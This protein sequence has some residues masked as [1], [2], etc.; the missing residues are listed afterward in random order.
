MSADRCT[1]YAKAVKARRIV[2]G[3]WV[4]LACDRHL[5]DLRQ[6]RKTGLVWRLDLAERAIDFFADLLVLEDGKPFVLEPYQQFIVGSLFGWYN[7]DG[8]RRFRDAYVET[9]KGSGKS[10]L[11]A[12]IG[13]KGLI[14]DGEPA[15]EVYSAATTQ[16]Q[17]K[18]V[19]KDADRMVTQSPELAEAIKQEAACLTYGTPESVFRPVSSEHRGLDGKRVHIGI[20]DELHEHPNA[21]VVDKIRAGTKRRKNALIFRITNSGFD[22]TSV[23]WKE[24]D[25][26]TKVLQGTIDNP[27]WF[28]YVC[29][30]DDKDSWTDEKVWP[31][32]NP[33]M[34]AGLP[35]LSYLREQVMSAVGMPSKENIVKRL[36]LCMWTEQQERWL[37]MDAWDSCPG[38]PIDPASLRGRPCM[39]GLDMASRSD[40]ASTC[41]LFGPDEEGYYEAVWR[42]WLP[43]ESI[44]SAKSKRPESVR[45]QLREWADQGWITLTSGDTT[46]YD[47][48]EEAVLQDVADFDVRKLPFDRWNVTQLVTHLKDAMGDERVIDFPQTMAAMTA[49]TKELEKIVTEG[50]LR[51]GGNPVARWMASNVTIKH[52]PNEQIKPDRDSEDREKIDGI[53]ALIMAIDMVMR[54]PADQSEYD[55]RAEELKRM[56]EEGVAGPTQ[57]LID[58]W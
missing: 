50:K 40:F 1:A 37:P 3:P 57:D 29:A 56:R 22:R 33:A 23:C 44:A 4:R 54:Q 52:G 34:A 10:P 32:A 45:L 6:R 5:R 38:E 12:G 2:A 48:I 58:A 16:D 7:A 36:N 49:P 14:A 25:Y 28:A 51:H 46:D 21:M 43:E 8:F 13:L 47:L 41:K 15:A 27:S 9:G 39:M 17:A 30:L 35:P 19:W 55:R 11:A 53:I 18:I 42:F 31:K 20:L 26:S 24:H